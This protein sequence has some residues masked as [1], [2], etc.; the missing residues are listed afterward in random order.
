MKC[1]VAGR[2]IYVT[3]TAKIYYDDGA[4]D[5]PLEVL[6]VFDWLNIGT[7]ALAVSN[8]D[9]AAGLNAAD[10][11]FWDA[12]LGVFALLEDN[13]TYNVI[14]Y[15]TG[16]MELYSGGQRRF[17]LDA[18]DGEFTGWD[19][20]GN[21]RTKLYTD[22]SGPGGDA[23]LV[24]NDTSENVVAALS[25]N[26]GGLA[27]IGEASGVPKT[28]IAPGD[29][30]LFGT[31]GSLNHTIGQAGIAFNLLLEDIDF[32]IDGADREAFRMNAGNN[33]VE[34]AWLNHKPTN[35]TIDASGNLTVVS[36]NV[37]VTG[38][39]GG[40]ADDDLVTIVAGTGITFQDG[41]RLI[42]HTA[43]DDGEI[44]LKHG[45]GNIYVNVDQI[46]LARS[47]IAELVY[48]ASIAKWCGAGLRPDNE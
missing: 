30:N 16:V 2:F 15:S 20:A 25:S 3:D 1:P 34:I 10:Q 18:V 47:S 41:D 27:Q 33:G 6:P 21:V 19:A 43:H 13:S 23:V 40:S 28:T 45:T 48:V 37:T 4:A 14:L 32:T 8:G 17:G 46:M 24:L 11:V 9:L 5:V 22:A 7:T 38:F 29:V 42:L 36:G 31:S 35:A 12:S 39:G 44:T 26:G